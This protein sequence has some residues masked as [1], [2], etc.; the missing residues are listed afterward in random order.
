[1]INEGSKS[2]WMTR[3]AGVLQGS[4]LCPYLFLLYIMILLNKITQI[5]D[6]S[7]MTHLSLLL[8]K[9]KNQLLKEDL[10]ENAQWSKTKSMT[11]TR[12]KET[13]WD[14]ANFNNGVIK[15]NKMHTHCSFSSDAT[16]GDH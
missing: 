11:F 7:H 15:D 16:W 3:S 14:D 5:L 10:I 6:Y 8:F 2:T 12:T 4:V 1:M 9:I 13:N